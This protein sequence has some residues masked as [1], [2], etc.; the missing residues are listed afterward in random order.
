MHHGARRY[1]VL[2]KKAGMPERNYSSHSSEDCTCVRTKRSIKDGM[3]GPIGS[4]THA[5]KHHKKFEKWNK[6]L[7]Y[8]KK[9]NTILYSIA[10]KSG[11]RREIKKIKKIRA[12]ASKN[13][14]VSSSED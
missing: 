6:E 9:Q 12:E 2:C 13:T 10:K 4:R 5:V 11:P 8:L 7:K 1:Y 3:G 14:S